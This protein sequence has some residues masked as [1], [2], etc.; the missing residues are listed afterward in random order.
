MIMLLYKNYPVRNDWTEM[1]VITQRN[2]KKLP[3]DSKE[4][5]IVVS[6]NTSP[7]F[8]FVLNSYKTAAKYSQKIIEVKDSL[9][10][11]KLLGNFSY[12]R[13][14]NFSR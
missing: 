11:K 14:V 2:Y 13:K 1:R 4:N 3:K 7:M 6:T 8:R 9:L 10:Q 12:T 5:F